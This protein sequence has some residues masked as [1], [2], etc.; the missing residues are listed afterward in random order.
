MGKYHDKKYLLITSN[1][2]FPYA[3]TLLPKNTIIINFNK[4]KNPIKF[5]RTILLLK[6][7]KYDLGFNPWSSADESEF[8][9]TYAKK[10][11]YFRWFFDSANIPMYYNLFDRV[12][13]YLSLPKEEP[14]KPGWDFKTKATRIVISP[15]SSRVAKSLGNTD[16]TQLIAQVRE[17]FPEADITIASPREELK[18][19]KGS[20]KIF[21]FRKTKAG[22]ESFLNLLKETD[23]VIS[24]DAGPMHLADSLGIPTIGV[25]G[26]TAPHAT[27]DRTTT[28]VPVRHQALHGFF[29][30]VKECQDPVCIHNLFAGS[31]LNHLDEDYDQVPELTLETGSCRATS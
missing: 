24:V 18:G 3:K 1:Q 29:C 11:M 28:V 10:F 13:D 26:P 15:F 31:F 23:L 17:N 16:L 9:I 6:K 4:R 30:H 14:V 8:L 19:I 27:L 22:S 5:I 7:E 25:F 12:R 21:V 2:L 20:Q